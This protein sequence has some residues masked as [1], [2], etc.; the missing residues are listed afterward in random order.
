M[1]EV[2][3]LRKNKHHHMRKSSLMKLFQFS[4]N[5]NELFNCMGEGASFPGANYLQK[6]LN[7]QDYHLFVLYCSIPGLNI[8]FL[9]Y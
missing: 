2:A 6:N 4:G 3:D 9:F 7:V 5:D 1:E 8:L